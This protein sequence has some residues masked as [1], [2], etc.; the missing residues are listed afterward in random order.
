MLTL[1]C[2]PNTRSLRAAWA[3]E[4]AG[5]DYGCVFVDLL[6]GAGRAPDYLKVNPGGKLPAL[7]FGENILTESGAILLWLAARH[8]GA[9]LLPPPTQEAEHA[10]ALRWLCFGLTELDQALWTIAKHRFALPDKHRVPAI[11]ATAKWEFAHAARLLAQRL[12]NVPYLAGDCF[13]AADIVAAHCLA[14]ARSARLELPE[15]ILDDYLQRMLSRPAVARAKAREAE[16]K[17]S[18]DGPRAS[19]D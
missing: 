8:P 12:E 1:Y 3:L 2:C 7:C 14:W 5:V 17:A 19:A 6:K 9:G 10:A 11:E 15:P 16:A 4:E 18:G 13:S